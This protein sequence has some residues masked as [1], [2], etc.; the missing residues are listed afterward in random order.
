MLT[1][2]FLEDQDVALIVDLLRSEREELPTELRRTEQAAL[3]DSLKQR[4]SRVNELLH[5]FEHEG[6]VECSNV[7]MPH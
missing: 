4:L 2:V 3:H 6:S 7:G 1:Q 5:K